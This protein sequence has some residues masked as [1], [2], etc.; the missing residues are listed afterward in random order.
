MGEN[1]IDITAFCPPTVEPVIKN[2]TRVSV[3]MGGGVRNTP[4]VSVA[5]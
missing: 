4:L 1:I 3:N 2:R 5:S